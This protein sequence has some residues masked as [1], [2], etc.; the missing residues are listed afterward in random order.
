MSR[1]IRVSWPSLSCEGWERTQ[2]T[3]HRYLQL[4]GKVR[5]SLVPP[6][7]HWW[8]T[9]LHLATRGLTTGPM[10]HGNREVEIALDLIDHRLLVLSSDG[11]E[12]CFELGARPA[13]ADFYRD[14]LTS[15]EH[16]G[17]QVD[18]VPVPYDLGPGPS[19]PD[20]TVHATYEPDAVTAYWRVL[21]GTGRVLEELASRF[22]GEASP[23]HLFWHRL[24]LCYT[25]HRL[26]GG[27][28]AS[29]EHPQ[30]IGFGFGVGDE[31]AVPFPAFYCY[32]DPEPP[33]LLEH[34]LEPVRAHWR[35][36]YSSHRAV[37]PYDVMRATADPSRT[38]LEFYET[39]YLL[40]ARS[41]GW[42]IDACSASTPPRTTR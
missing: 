2:Q 30:V 6:R 26:G 7:H 34:S 39:A 37:L 20:D 42:D 36:V 13:C 41:A 31:R 25:R 33:R 38:L 3:L 8:H 17:V 21:A 29:R 5:M 19:F 22:S 12:R 40:T 18:I 24:D 32:V 4:V 9:T 11:R 23:I 27:T 15:L 1:N 14:L 16:V 35:E 10:P 28:T